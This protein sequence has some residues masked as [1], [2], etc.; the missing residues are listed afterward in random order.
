MDQLEACIQVAS[1]SP[2]H[3]SP[4]QRVPKHCGVHK[5]VTAFPRVLLAATNYFRAKKCR[6]YSSSGEKKKKQLLQALNPRPLD[7]RI[8]HLAN[9][10]N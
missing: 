7:Y 5:H 4:V 1:S 3:V 6:Y 8:H 9:C 2:I 10:I